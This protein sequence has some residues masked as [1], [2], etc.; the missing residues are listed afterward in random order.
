MPEDIHVTI[1]NMK[2]VHKM[3]TGQLDVDPDTRENIG[4]TF[5]QDQ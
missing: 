3:N 4:T 2:T 5:A 1:N